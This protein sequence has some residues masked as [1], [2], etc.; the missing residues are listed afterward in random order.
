M[1][2]Q[3]L[4]NFLTV[5]EFSCCL[6]LEFF[7]DHFV[8]LIFSHPV[9]ERA[10]EHEFLSL[11]ALLA[12]FSV[13]EGTE[14]K[15]R[16]GIVDLAFCRNRPGSLE[17]LDIH[18][19][20]PKLQR[21]CHGH[22]VR[23]Q[24]DLLT[25][26]HVKV[27][28]LHLGHIVQI[29]HLVI[30]FLG[31]IQWISA[32]VFFLEECIPLFVFEDVAVSDIALFHIL[33]STDQEAFSLEFRK[34]CDNLC[35]CLSEPL[36]KLLISAKRDILMVDIVSAEHLVRTFSGK[37]YLEVLRTAVGDVVQKVRARVGQR[38]VHVILNLLRIVEIFFRRYLPSDIADAKLVCQFLCVRRFAVF[39]L[40]KVDRKCRQIH[41]VLQF[42]CHV[43]G[44]HAA[45]KE[46]TYRHVC[47]DMFVY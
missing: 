20:N 29:R 19:R 41:L 3:K 31:N 5:K 4:Q 36:R 12:E 11:R 6:A 45:G 43:A 7:F 21:V 15:L 8:I 35:H 39:L 16:V 25:Q 28:I 10:R 33:A 9:R 2:F 37:C 40:Y 23:F 38:L 46:G 14:R 1:F 24:K 47:D 26:P 17:D 30:K 27:Q 42:I 34:R 44:I 13:C 18:K 32:L 22:L